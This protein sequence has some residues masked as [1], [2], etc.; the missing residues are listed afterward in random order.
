MRIFITCLFVLS[1]TFLFAEPSDRYLIG[2]HYYEWYNKKSWTKIESRPLLGKYNS[3]DDDV[4]AQHLQWA[5][6]YGID[7]FA[8]EWSG[9][10]KFSDQAIYK[11][12]AVSPELKNVSF[13]ISYDTLGR[14]GRYGNP[15]Y[16]FSD[17]RILHD[18]LADFDY[19]SQRYFSNPHYLKFQG[20]PVVW[21]YIA[22]GMRGDWIGALQQAREV[23]KKNGFDLYLD[24]D[25]LQPE[26]TDRSRFPYF[27]AISAYTVNQPKLFQRHHVKTTEDVANLS[28]KQF[29]KWS[30][31]V[32]GTRNISSG[33][34]IA[35][36]PV[37]TPQFDDPKSQRSA[38]YWLKS[39]DD[40]RKFAENARDHA[41]YD[42]V[43]QARVIWITSWNEWYEGSAIEPT[44]EG[45]SLQ[46]EYGFKLLEVIKSVFGK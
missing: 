16:N 20:R 33:N 17:P 8:L 2:A 35:F 6:Q 36:H 18:F 41:T 14:F 22:R 26:Q 28:K 31:L 43:A 11:H 19:L 39:V 40:F 25:L 5:A 24:G 15:P 3:M 44:P 46:N 21:L 23:V 12:I 30:K 9:I 7:F 29:E 37:I 10:H 34:S 4:I 1:W 13:C 27:D 32:S 38:E 45:T 42:E